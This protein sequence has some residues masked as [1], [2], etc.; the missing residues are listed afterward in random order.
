M[1]SNSEAFGEF[2]STC[3]NPQDD[4][5]FLAAQ[6]RQQSKRD[7]AEKFTKVLSHEMGSGKEVTELF[8][9]HCL[10]FH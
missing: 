7:I 4:T 5:N 8:V 2:F 10:M 3:L 1:L 6:K 9:E